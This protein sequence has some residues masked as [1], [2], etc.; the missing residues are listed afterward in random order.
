MCLLSRYSLNN[1]REW[2]VASNEEVSVLI[3]N[4]DSSIAARDWKNSNLQVYW[5]LSISPSKSFNALYFS[6]VEKWIFLAYAH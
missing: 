1:L 5:K 6:L 4:F 2:F 3:L